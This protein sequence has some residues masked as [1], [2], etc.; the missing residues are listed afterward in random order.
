M[1]KLYDNGGL[2]N[3]VDSVTHKVLIS[4]TT[5]RSFISPQVLKITP[6][7]RQICGCALCITLKDIHIY[8]NI[9]RKES[10]TYLQH[11]SVTIHTC[12]SAYINKSAEHYKEKMFPDGVFYMLLSKMQISA[13]PVF[14]LNQILLL[15][16]IVL[17][18]FEM[19][20]LSRTFLIK[21]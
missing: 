4:D 1:I 19:I 3:V 2:D 5:L 6:R 7:L 12:N 8:L 13:C 16:S 14:L 18:V 11:K 15:I 21:N 17:W 10:V 9:S 20:F